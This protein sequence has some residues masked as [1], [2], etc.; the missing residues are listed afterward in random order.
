MGVFTRSDPSLF[1]DKQFLRVWAVGCFTGIVRWLELLA[2]GLFAYD[3]TGSPVLVALLALLRFAPLALFGVFVGAIAD[4]ID[5]RKLLIAGLAGIVLVNAGMF[6]LFVFDLADYWHVAVATFLSGVFWSGDLPLRRRMIG[7]LVPF[8]RLAEAMALDNATS[9]GTRMLGPLV[10]GVIYQ[11]VGVAGVFALGTVLH[12]LSLLLILSVVYTT[13]LDR[14]EAGSLLM[15]PIRGAARAVSFSWANSD[16]MRIFAVTIVFNLWGFPFVSMIPVI[17]K[18]QLAL[19]D[20]TIGYLTALEGAF[21]LIGAVILSR[22]ARPAAFRKLY[23]FGVLGHLGAV[24]FIGTVPGIVP[25][26]IGLIAAGSFAACFS[27]MQATLIYSVAPPEMRGRLLGL[28]T[29]CIGTGVIGF[30]NMGL[31]AEL[32]GAST[33]LWIVALEGV[34]PML[35]IGWTWRELNT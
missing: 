30:A 10:G 14:P 33:A 29:I 11:A 5:A 8:E 35:L 4:L 15:R 3:V 13:V 25:V 9:N 22:I 31:T 16:V 12:G 34:I 18:E 1:S 7:E 17:G 20:A 21:A 28:M 26:A 32:F 27:T 2:F 24:I 19:P 6:A 23:Y